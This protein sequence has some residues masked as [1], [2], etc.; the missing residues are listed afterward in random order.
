MSKSVSSTAA[1]AGRQVLAVEA[2]WRSVFVQFR[3][4]FSSRFLVVD[5]G[6]VRR[7][8]YICAVTTGKKRKY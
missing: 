7:R 1:A 8:R 3:R 6:T 4:N 2:G 5:Y